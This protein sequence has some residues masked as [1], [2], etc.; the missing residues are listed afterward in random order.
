MPHRFRSWSHLATT[1]L[2]LVVL[3]ACGGASEVAPVCAISAVTVVVPVASLTVGQTTQAAAAYTVQN[4]TPLPTIAWASDN[5]AVASVSATGL[6]TGVVAGGPVTIRATVGSQVGSAAVTVTRVPVAT[7]ALTGGAPVMVPGRGAQFTA[8]VRDAGGNVLTG[9]TVT[10][11]SSNTTVATVVDGAVSTFS[12]GGPVTITATV[13]G[14][15][16]TA[17]LTVV[18]PVNLAYGLADNATSTVPYNVSESFT[19]PGD[20]TVSRKTATGTYELRILGLGAST[21]N[22]RFLYINSRVATAHCHPAGEPTTAASGAMVAQIVC[23]SVTTGAA[24]DAPYSFVALGTDAFTGRTGF[25]LTP[26]AAIGTT[27]V[28][29]TSPF[30]ATSRGTDASVLVRSATTG[31][32]FVRFSALGRVTGDVAENHFAQ[33]WG[34]TPGTWCASAGWNSSGFDGA[35]VCYDA[36]GA[37]SN[38]RFATLVIDRGRPTKR[39]AVSWVDLPGDASSVPTSGWTYST[40]GSVSVARVSA[41]VHDV[42]FTNLATS[43][44]PVG[45]MVSSYGGVNSHCTIIQTSRSGSNLVARV[46][47]VAPVTG[48]PRDQLFSIGVIE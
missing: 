18:A 44:A 26:T 19:N 22:R 42:T 9:R 15:S 8:T 4:C 20:S 38:E 35:V 46:N 33:S 41:G 30:S 48:A 7:V 39:F 29:V 47:C 36:N 11:S 32:Y 14:V 34:T 24:V 12:V 31:G 27:D 16:A 43:T 45:I 28:V 13:E 6:V 25:L 23:A 21:A 37:A 1:T 17:T 10:W 40:G 3:Q 2:G 5:A